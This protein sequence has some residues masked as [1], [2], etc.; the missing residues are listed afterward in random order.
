M[1]GEQGPQGEQGIQGPAGPKGDTGA[2]GATGPQGA[3]GLQGI[4]GIPGVA[5]ANGA[6]GPQGEQGIQGLKGDT[7]ATG[8]AGPQGPPLTYLGYWDG[9]YT[10]RVGDVVSYNGS[11]YISMYP[12]NL[13]NSPEGFAPFA[14][15]MPWWGLLAAKGDTGAT[16]ATGDTGPQGPQG[17]QGVQ[18]DQGIQGPI[19]LT[20]ATGDTGAQGPKGDV[21]ATFQGLW[22]PEA[23]YSVGDVVYY[24]GSSYVSLTNLNSNI[25][26]DDGFPWTLLAAKG[27]T[28]ATG[29]TGDT[30]P[31]G[32]QGIQGPQGLTGDTGPQGPQGDTGA[33]GPMGPQGPQ[34]DTGPQGPMG[35]S[36]A[37]TR[38]VISHTVSVTAGTQAT[39]VATCGVDE[40]AI[41]GGGQATDANA[42]M[43]ASWPSGTRTWSVT[44]WNNSAGPVDVTSFVICVAATNNPV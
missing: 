1:T 28:G 34:G 44:F 38:N 40:V 3:Q 22:N 19:G 8:P 36:I 14:F 17:I 43:N 11:S 37:D 29:P 39:V 23:S 30:G 42:S 4:Q 16:G 9:S 27:D 12:M 26:P 20:G 25:A 35:P 21:G 10:Y 7:G 18:G 2:T 6:Q 32:P 13:D 31:Q 33:T 24:L 5:G 15:S 41:G